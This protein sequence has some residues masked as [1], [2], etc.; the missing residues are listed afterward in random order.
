MCGLYCDFAAAEIQG[1]VFLLEGFVCGSTVVLQ[2]L[3]FKARC[4]Y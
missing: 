1:K 4:F 3:R 2:Q